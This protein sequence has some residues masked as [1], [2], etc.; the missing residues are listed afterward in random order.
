MIRMR[1]VLM[2]V[3]VRVVRSGSTSQSTRVRVN[4]TPVRVDSVNSQ[5][6]RVRLGFRSET[7]LNQHPGSVKDG[8]TSVSSL[9]CLI[10]SARIQFKSNGQT[11]INDSQLS[12]KR[13]QLRPGML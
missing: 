8:Q 13:G 4:S 7:Q 6:K 12:V 10:R 2:S 9:V 11:T 1:S 5:S 3:R